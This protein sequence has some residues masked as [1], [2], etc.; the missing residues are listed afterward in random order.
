MVASKALYLIVEVDTIVL[1]LN[2]L[3]MP[4]ERMEALDEIMG[5][6]CPRVDTDGS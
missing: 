3:W 2:W 6:C 1:A 4:G 5:T